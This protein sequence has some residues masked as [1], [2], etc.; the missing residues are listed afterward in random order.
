MARTKLWKSYEI[1]LRT[2]TEDA[3]IPLESVDDADEATLA[4]HQQLQR[5]KREGT[6]GELVLLN[7]DGHDELLEGGL[8]LRLPLG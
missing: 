8:V 2:D 5:L 3:P 6:T 4:F 1:I 7:R